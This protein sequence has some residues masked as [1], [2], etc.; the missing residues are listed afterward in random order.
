MGHLWMWRV[1]T[2]VADEHGLEWKAMRKIA[3]VD[4]F[5]LDTRDERVISFKPGCCELQMK[6]S[7]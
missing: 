2:H 1:L 3:I 6:K 7:H 4:W 5:G